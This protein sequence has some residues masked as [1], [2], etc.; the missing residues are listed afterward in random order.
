MVT[1]AVMIW[2]LEVFRGSTSYSWRLFELAKSQ[3]IGFV[4]VPDPPGNYM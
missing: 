4:G 3:F 1:I 2:I